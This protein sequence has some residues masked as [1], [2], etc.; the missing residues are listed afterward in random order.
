[1]ALSKKLISLL[2]L[3]HN[4]E[5]TDE[6]VDFLNIVFS[7]RIRQ[8]LPLHAFAWSVYMA[9]SLYPAPGQHPL[10]IHPPISEQL[11]LESLDDFTD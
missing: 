4:V 8:R 11:K 5:F 10:F 1:M 6:Q 3:R 2:E 9:L 7:K